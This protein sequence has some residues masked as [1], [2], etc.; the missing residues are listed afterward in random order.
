MCIV[1]CK[2]KGLRGRVDKRC[3]S[4][5][6]WPFIAVAGAK[7]LHSY[8]VSLQKVGGTTQV[9]ARL[10]KVY[11]GAHGFVL[12]KYQFDD[13]QSVDDIKCLDVTINKIQLLVSEEWLFNTKHSSIL[14]AR[15]FAHKQGL[16]R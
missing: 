9:P 1:K 7:N 16:V 15:L 3:C 11:G 5:N 4:V 14:I 2:K 8:P 13:S 10:L 12:H 6:H